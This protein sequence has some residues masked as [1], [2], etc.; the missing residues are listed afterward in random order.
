[1][2]IAKPIPC[3]KCYKRP[4]TEQV[5]LYGIRQVKVYCPKCGL[6]IYTPVSAK[7][8]PIT[9]WNQC[10][11]PSSFAINERIVTTRK[12]APAS[13]DP[14]EYINLTTTPIGYLAEECLNGTPFEDLY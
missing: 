9:R 2:S 1:M 11:R 12:T 7:I 14:A 13:A 5:E 3:R 6:S 10:V 4:I 8:N